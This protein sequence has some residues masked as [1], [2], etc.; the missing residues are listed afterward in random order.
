MRKLSKSSPCP[1]WTES[2]FKLPPQKNLKGSQKRDGW[3]DGQLWREGCWKVVC[4]LRTS[5]VI[6]CQQREM[7]EVCFIQ[8]D[9]EVTDQR[10]KWLAQSDTLFSSHYFSEKTE[11]MIS[12]EELIS[13]LLYLLWKI[14]T[15]VCVLIMTPWRLHTLV[16]NC[17][18]QKRVCSFFCFFFLVTVKRAQSSCHGYCSTN[19]SCIFIMR[20]CEHLFCRSVQL[21]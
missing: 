20:L 3:L 5:G 14:K 1:G 19:K 21:D 16:W 6:S 12:A 9:H 10:Q 7:K 18:T 4:E 15:K 8:A 2:E 11:A 17:Q 13:P